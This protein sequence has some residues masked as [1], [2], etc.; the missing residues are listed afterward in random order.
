MADVIA[1]RRTKRG[2]HYH[3]KMIIEGPFSG[4]PVGDV[5]QDEIDG[6]RDCIDGAQATIRRA[7]EEIATEQ[8][9][10]AAWEA[11]IAQLEAKRGQLSVLVAFPP[12]VEKDEL[13]PQLKPI[14][15]KPR[16]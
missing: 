4:E 5:L 6:L 3:F 13:K 1:L 11:K 7:L 10:I 15:K 16:R 12:S 8:E 9:L 14:K 2:N